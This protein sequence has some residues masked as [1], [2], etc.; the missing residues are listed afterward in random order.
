MLAANYA[1]ASDAAKSEGLPDVPPGKVLISLGD[2]VVTSRERH[3]PFVRRLQV[4]G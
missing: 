4:K 1:I 2:F 3:W